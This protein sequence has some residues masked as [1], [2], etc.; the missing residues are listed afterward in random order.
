MQ[1]SEIPSGR[2]S[3][4][5]A[6]YQKFLKPFGLSMA[7][8]PHTGSNCYPPGYAIAAHRVS[9]KKYGHAVVYLDGKIAHDPYPPRLTNGRKLLSIRHW[10]V[11]TVL[12]P[13]RQPP[14]KINPPIRVIS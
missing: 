13:A 1:I 12:D 14:A 4:W 6:A 10:F 8:T 5:V 11:F 7:W 3:R 2:G 9:G